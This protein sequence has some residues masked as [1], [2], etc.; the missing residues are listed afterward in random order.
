MHYE[1]HKAALQTNE[2]KYMKALTKNI[3]VIFI[4]L[5]V[6][7]SISIGAFGG[8]WY[9]KR[10]VQVSAIGLWM[11][12]VQSL[13]KREYDYALFYIS[14]AIGLKNDDPLFFQAMAEAYEA[15]QNKSM[16][17]EFYRIALEQYKEENKGPIKRIERKIELLQA[18]KEKNG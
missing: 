16:A 14:Q 8:V 18:Q 1:W 3:K 10:L 5:L 6:L 9:Y 4:I 13:E 2:V 17:L 15:K 7:V 11:T 12:G